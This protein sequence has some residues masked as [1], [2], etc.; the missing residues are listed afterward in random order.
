[1]G[2]TDPLSSVS[3]VMLNWRDAETTCL[4]V[5][6]LLAEGLV[7]RLIVVDNESDG[8]LRRLLDNL[9]DDRLE[10]IE[11]SVNL[12]FSAGMNVGLRR[13]LAVDPGAVVVAIN[14]DAHFDGPCALAELVRASAQQ[15]QPTMVAP[16]IRLPDGS[17]SSTGGVFRLSTMT[18]TDDL[19]SG[20][21]P[22]FLTWACVAIHPQVLMQQGLLSERFFLYWE[23]VEF[24]LRLKAAGVPMRVVPSSTVVHAV[25]SSHARA[26]PRVQ[27]Y[28]ALGVVSLARTLGVRCLPGAVFRLGGRL[29]RAMARRDWPAVRAIVRGTFT[30]LAMRRS[31]TAVAALQRR[32]LVGR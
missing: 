21:Q 10:L 18:T 28:S 22:D 13:A 25:S 30:G 27:A 5:E 17:L 15:T 8:S 12:G 4:A 1:M 3:C 14:S 26:G 6:R 19:P 16:I 29:S 31:E 11:Q 7:A 2:T 9:Q 23:D 24:G 32:G 20:R